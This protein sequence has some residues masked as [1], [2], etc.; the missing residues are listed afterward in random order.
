MK[1]TIKGK[2]PSINHAYVNRATKNRVI[3][4]LS[5][6]GKDYQKTVKEQFEKQIDRAPYMDDVMIT[7]D[8]YFPDNRRRDWDN[9][10]K[11]L[12]DA[13][14]H[15]AFIDDSQ[16]VMAHVT[17][18]VDKGCPRVEVEVMPLDE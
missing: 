8:F 1:F 7:L 16:I 11:T 15:K 6:A 10:A 4:F 3:R 5:K 18:Q 2:P 14:E 17:K 9:Y 12:Q 13:L